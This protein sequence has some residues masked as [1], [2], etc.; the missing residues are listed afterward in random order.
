MKIAQTILKAT[1]DFILPQRC[2]VCNDEIVQGLL[3]NNCLDYLPEV[4][5]TLCRFCG[6]PTK[7]RNLCGFCK[8][9]THLDYGR[10]FMLFIPPYDKIIH[11]FK[12]RKKTKLAA[13]FGRAMASIIKSDHYLKDVD[14]IAPVPLFWWKNLRRGYNQAALLSEIISQE[15]NI[16]MNDILKRIINTKTQTKLNEEARRKNVLDAFQ[17]KQNGIKGKR[18]VLVDDVMTTGVTINECARVLKDAGAKK[19]Y[20]CVA[21]ITPG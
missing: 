11:H 16:K 15:C 8:K 3:C 7:K 17:V 14:I 5:P 6:R 18:V 4:K 12:Y 21:A 9:G 10:A 1:L 20:S 2:I 19:V 13:F